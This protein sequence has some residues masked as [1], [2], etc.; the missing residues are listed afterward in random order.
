MK[1]RCEEDVN[2]IF[3]NVLYNFNFIS[4]K[5][6]LECC[7]LCAVLGSIFI[8]ILLMNSVLTDCN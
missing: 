5:V 8:F 4:I 1:C 6:A 3:N 2:D 7:A